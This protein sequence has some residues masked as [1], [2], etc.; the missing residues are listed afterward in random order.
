MTP[1]SHRFRDPEL[2]RMAAAAE[3]TGATMMAA[4]AQAQQ[5]PAPGQYFGLPGLTQWTEQTENNNGLVAVLGQSAGGPVQGILPFKQ[6]D[7]V[8]W[9]EVTVTWTN[10]VVPGTQ[11]INTSPYFPYN[12]FGE[13][14]LKIQNQFDSW[15]IF[16][17]VDAAIFQMIR[18]MR[19]G[20]DL[21]E[22]LG[23]NPAGAWSSN[24]GWE[25]ANLPQANLDA[26]AGALS[27]TGTINFSLELPGSLRFDQ[28]YDLAE[29]G[30]LLANPA[31]AW[32]SPQFM[33]G[34]ARQ[35][36]PI[37][38]TPA[39][40][41]AGLDTS[42]FVATGTITTPATASGNLAL[43]FRRVGIYSSNNQA[44]M[45][46]VRHWQ[47]LRDVSNFSLSGVN[48][49]DLI[50]PT[51]GQILSLFVRLWDPSANGGIGA[52]ISIANI[53]KC[54]VQFGSGLLRF[55][56]TPRD[57]QRRFV[58]QHGVLLPQ[59]VLAWDMAIDELG[60]ITN[61]RALNT[62]NTAG[63]QVHFEFSSALST[64]AY[65]V[66]GVEALTYVV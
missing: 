59:G 39:V 32:V 5:A 63:V 10:T 28:Y 13:S 22:N 64:T 50:V 52:P 18:P 60:K 16:S 45:P 7:V 36:S 25:N 2:A 11:T 29:D 46:V 20:T 34:S 40:L 41:G 58:R 24:G 33:A 26:T 51:V 65:A 42:P 12:I 19:P 49:K 4:A 62:L 27:S 6:V 35:V 56:D 61:A 55:D 15:H 9:W 23:A 44:A 30:T 37:L 53:T 38:A 66:L 31:P 8:F 17:G 21:R 47:Y 43:G 48:R 57:A 1:T 54:Q 14:R 3:A